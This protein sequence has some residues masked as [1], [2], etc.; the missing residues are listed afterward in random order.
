MSRQ[1]FAQALPAVVEFSSPRAW[2]F[3]LLGIQEYLQRLNGD[4]FTHQMRDSLTTRLMELYDRTARAERRRLE[5]P[6]AAEFSARAR[7]TAPGA[8]ALPIPLR[9]SGRR[10]AVMEFCPGQ[11]DRVGGCAGLDMNLPS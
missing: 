10:P 11:K 9:S 1:I 2:A 7:K 8:G 3:A 4:R 5:Y 6:R